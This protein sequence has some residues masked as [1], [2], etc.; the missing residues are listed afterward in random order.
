[1]ARHVLLNCGIPIDRPALAVNRLCGSGFQ[2]VV[3]G[4]QDILLGTAKVSLTGGVDNMSQSPFVVRNMRFGSTLGAK[5][6][7]EDS[8]WLGLTDSYCNLPMAVT[9]ENLAV[10]Y[11]LS[12]KEVDEFALR[13]QLNWKKA[14]DDGVFKSEITPVTIKKKGKEIDFIVDEHPR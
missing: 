13:S 4:A 8:L 14:N 2:S 11:N 6:D 5:Y 1:M 3:N 7:F 9:A 12:R 10:K